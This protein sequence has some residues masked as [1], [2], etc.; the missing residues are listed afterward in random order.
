MTRYFDLSQP[1]ENRMSFFPG[2]PQ[3]EIRP[4]QA[5]AAP[6]RVSELHIGTHTGTH[7]DAASHYVEQGAPI[8]RYPIERFILP[9]ICVYIESLG[10]DEP[11]GSDRLAA[12]V[13]LIPKGGALVIRTAWDQY[14]GQELYYRHP[15][16][17]PSAAQRLVEAGAGLVGIDALNVDSTTLG[18][19][20]VHAALLG[21]DILIV[22]NLRGLDQ[23][24]PGEVYYFSFL[25]LALS[26]LDGSP[27]RAV[28]WKD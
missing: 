8:S 7:I 1:I 19:S 17:T 18:A 21:K 3:P 22:E 5:V 28:A 10:P 6:W 16:L 14:W 24:D 4:A 25:P 11:V 9:G 12:A 23:L 27:V 2:D 20:Q 15:Y 26:G 13:A